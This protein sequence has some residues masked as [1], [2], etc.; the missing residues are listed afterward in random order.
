MSPATIALFAGS[1][2]AQLM[3]ISLLPRTEGF[4]KVLPTAACCALFLV[5]LGA[6]ANL[7]RKGVELGVLIPMISAIIPLVTIFIGILFYGE[8]ASVLK[9]SLLMGACVLIAGASAFS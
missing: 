5:G 6:M 7:T 8:S 1:V 2:I 3:A 4:T 9:V